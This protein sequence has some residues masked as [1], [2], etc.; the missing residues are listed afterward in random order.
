MNDPEKTSF[1]LGSLPWLS[2]MRTRSISAENPSGG[3]GKGG[4][5]VPN[6]TDPDLPHS[7]AAADLGQ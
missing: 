6:P 1:G 2:R 3:K 7:G 4:M 5:A